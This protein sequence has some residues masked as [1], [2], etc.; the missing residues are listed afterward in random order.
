MTDKDD[1]AEEVKPPDTYE[2]PEQSADPV[3]NAGG[4]SSGDTADSTGDKPQLDDN[5]K[6]QI[7][8]PS[9]NKQAQARSRALH[10]ALTSMFGTQIGYANIFMQDGHVGSAVAGNQYSGDITSESC[11]ASGPVPA[12]VLE[13]I[14]HTFVAPSGYEDVL[15]VLQDRSVVL[16]RAASGTG[17]T[18]TA[19][20][21]LQEECGSGVHKLDPDTTLRALR[22]E[23]LVRNT[24]YLLESVDLVEG[25]RL[26]T[27]RLDR[28]AGQLQ[29]HG[30]KLVVLIETAGARTSELSNFLVDGGTVPDISEVVRRHFAHGTRRGAGTALLQRSD[31]QELI[32]EMAA[33][34]MPIRDIA[35]FAR[36]IAAVERGRIGLSTI[37][38]RYSAAAHSNFVTWFDQQQDTDQRALAISLA[39]F[40]GMPLHTVSAAA[41]LLAD[42]IRAVETPSK[43]DRTRRVFDVPLSRRIDHAQAELV[44]SAEDTPHGP[45]ATKIARYR[46]NRFP[47]KVLEHVCKEHAEAHHLV[48]DWLRELAR[49]DDVG[50]RARV[51]VAVGLL[52]RSEFEHM[53]QLVLLPWATCGGWRERDAAVGAMHASSLHPELAPL[54][55]RMLKRWLSREADSLTQEQLLWRRVTAAEAIGS[56]GATMPDWAIARLRRAALGAPVELATAISRSMTELLTR[57]ECLGR[58]LSALVDWSDERRQS[59]R[60]TGLLSALRVCWTTTVDAGGSEAWPAVVWIANENAE[61]ASPIVSLLARLLDA[62]DFMPWGYRCL[63]RWVWLA[64]RD[65]EFRTPLGKV[66]VQIAAATGEQTSIRQHLVGLGTARRRPTA[67]VSELIDMLDRKEGDSEPAA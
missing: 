1:N 4:S 20:H 6:E 62:P 11:M 51:G 37:L 58:V 22:V 34:R 44:D 29:D 40:N 61:Y 55:T 50:V 53:R 2:R 25:G 5:T 38:S 32:A 12:T 9:E 41:R 56:I 13:E 33:T 36:E 27:F 54:I 16:L 57:P 23:S 64:E 47:R 66:L 63:G 3:S 15:R 30:C 46:D 17:R 18:T 7:T 21:I 65:P 52:S 45:V 14:T 35:A 48:R 26:S 39:V 19:L 28:L 42:R 8:D 43:R 31:V 24:G 10:D 60:Q 67:A 59:R 49:Y